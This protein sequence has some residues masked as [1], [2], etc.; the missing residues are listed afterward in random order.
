M[1]C[2]VQPV[3]LQPQ[4]IFLPLTAPTASASTVRRLVIIVAAQSRVRVTLTVTAMMT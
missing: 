1:L 4:L 3:P 2:L